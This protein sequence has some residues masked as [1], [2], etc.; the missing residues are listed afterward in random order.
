MT[1]LL[2]NIVA[3]FDWASVAYFV[4]TIIENYLFLNLFLLICDEKFSL[5]HKLLYLVSIVTISKLTSLF[6]PSPFNVI[7]NYTCVYFLVRMIFKISIIKGI[8][9]TIIT[10]FVFGLINILIQN[11]YL[12]L[13]K[14]SSE[15]FMKDP[16]YRITY[17]VVL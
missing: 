7:I 13:L 14:L 1:H 3:N 12:T 2:N 15:E 16:K 4:A 6:V 5:K 10:S 8:T 11:P 9:S 17:L